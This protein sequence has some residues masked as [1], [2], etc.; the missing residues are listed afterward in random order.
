MGFQVINYDN[1]A[2]N[3]KTLLPSHTISTNEIL[4]CDFTSI[5]PTTQVEGILYQSKIHGVCR[6]SDLY[7]ASKNKSSSKQRPRLNL[8]VRK[9]LGGKVVAQSSMAKGPIGGSCGFV[10]E[11]RMPRRSSTKPSTDLHRCQIESNFTT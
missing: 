2:T 7:L 10:T 1:Q 5:A 9:E 4:G 11:T 3:D 8:T 6:L